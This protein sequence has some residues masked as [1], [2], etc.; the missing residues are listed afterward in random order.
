MAYGW[1]VLKAY[2][3][4]NIDC[5]RMV[6]IPTG[7]NSSMFRER[8]NKRLDL[9][10]LIMN[11]QES[12]CTC[13]SN[14]HPVFCIVCTNT[15]YNSDIYENSNHIRTDIKIEMCIYLYFQ[16]RIKSGADRSFEHNY[17]YIAIL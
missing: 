17:L 12:S 1:D 9:R 2:F 4:V 14:Y 13:F 10:I 5:A 8:L 15:I 7:V 16:L 3:I 6:N 11:S